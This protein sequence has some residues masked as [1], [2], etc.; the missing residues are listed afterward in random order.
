MCVHH[1]PRFLIVGDVTYSEYAGIFE[2]FVSGSKP[3]PKLHEGRACSSSDFLMSLANGPGWVEIVEPI[4]GS[5]RGESRAGAHC[6]PFP[7]RHAPVS[8]RRSAAH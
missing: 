7:H 2:D 8:R 1:T 4:N 3:E 5:G 6:P